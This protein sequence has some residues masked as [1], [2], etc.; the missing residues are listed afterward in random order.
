MVCIRIF[1]LTSN[2]PTLLEDGR[3]PPNSVKGRVLRLPLHYCAKSLVTINSGRQK[4]LVGCGRGGASNGT[5]C[6]H[7]E[8]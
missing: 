1:K 3:E 5:P 7:N 8:I 4:C 6:I 2:N